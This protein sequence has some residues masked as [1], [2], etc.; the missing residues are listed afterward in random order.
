MAKVLKIYKDDAPILREICE[1]IKVID[2]KIIDLATN[3]W[4]TVKCRNAYGLAAN[5]VGY[6]FRIIVINT[7]KLKDVFINPV[8]EE[9]EEE[10]FDFEEGCL[11]V[12]NVFKNLGKRSRYITI[13]YMDLQ[14]HKKRGI[15]TD[16]DAVVMQHEVDHLN[17]IL[18]TD[19]EDKK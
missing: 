14:G 1:E 16:I 9:K 5:Q 8:I 13:S 6:K 2:D 19:Y 12:P 7:P 11:S 18:F 4:K 3:M 17:G 10:L 15:L